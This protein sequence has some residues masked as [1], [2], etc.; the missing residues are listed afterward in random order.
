MFNRILL[1]KFERKYSLGSDFL[2]MYDIH[3][4]RETSRV[5]K[6]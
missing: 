1:V 5:F 6:S 4:Q 2:I 3:F